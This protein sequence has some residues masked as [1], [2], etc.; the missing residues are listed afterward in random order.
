MTSSALKTLIAITII[1]NSL[2]LLTSCEKEKNPTGSSAVPADFL[3]KND[4]IQGWNKGD[5]QD[6]YREATDYS[7]LYDIIDG[8]AEVY[9]NHGF[10]EGVHQNYYGSIQSSSKTL[11]LL[12]YDMGDSTNAYNLYH[13][14]AIIPTSH[15]TQDFGDEARLDEGALF[16]YALDFRLDKYY[17]E[18]TLN[19]EGNEVEALQ[20]LRQFAL[21][22][23]SN[24]EN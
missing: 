24:M 13:D 1:S 14:P 6:D 15:S 5:G 12:I 17:V 20:V 4:D 16:D 23:E 7:S 9:I 19:K 22:V 8:G 10:I 21:A 11:Q 18:L 3:P 2:I